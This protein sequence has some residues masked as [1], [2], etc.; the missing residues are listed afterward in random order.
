MNTKE[1]NRIEP[2]ERVNQFISNGFRE[3][4][5][6][7]YN[8]EKEFEC[9]CSYSHENYHEIS[10]NLITGRYQSFN[11]NCLQKT[12]PKEFTKLYLSGYYHSNTIKTNREATAPVNSENKSYTFNNEDKKTLEIIIKHSRFNKEVTEKL[13]KKRPV[14]YQGLNDNLPGTWGYYD[15][16]II[17]NLIKEKIIKYEVVKRI[18]LLYSAKLNKFRVLEC[19]QDYSYYKAYNLEPE[20][21]K[22]N[23]VYNPAGIKKIIYNIEKIKPD[24]KKIYIFESTEKALSSEITFNDG[25]IVCLG[26]HGIGTSLNEYLD[27]FQDKEVYI[28]FDKRADKI[29]NTDIERT[30]ALKRAI[31]LTKVTKNVFISEIPYLNKDI[32]IDDYLELF[33]KDER[34]D[35]LNEVINNCFEIPVYKSLY[36]VNKVSIPLDETR[37][38]RQKRISKRIEK[39]IEYETIEQIKE[40][41]IKNVGYGIINFHENKEFKALLLSSQAGTGTVSYT[42]LT[43]PTSDLV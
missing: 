1:N 32:D 13:S 25:S 30:N 28:I 14:I 36:Q 3:V 26:L 6:Q 35:K 24:T 33:P 39:K 29:K 23:K 15:K 31:E 7:R 2:I 10:V 43:L 21:N 4:P 18:G 37:R 22:E 5:E 27:L 11:N 34:K 9:H 8:N 42:H 12:N 38:I 19:N 17:D 20:I 40:N 41:N 16:D